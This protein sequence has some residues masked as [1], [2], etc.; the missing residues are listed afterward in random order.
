[1]SKAKPERRRTDVTDWDH[2]QSLMRDVVEN[3][4]GAWQSLLTEL[5]PE[6][7]RFAKRQPIGRLRDDEDSP[8]EIAVRVVARLHANDRRSLKMMFQENPHGWRGRGR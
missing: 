6:L 8:R 1:M 4:D 2:I 5:E 7:V 3:G